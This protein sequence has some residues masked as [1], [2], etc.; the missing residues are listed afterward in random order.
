VADS[1]AAD[2]LHACFEP[3]LPAILDALLRDH[4]ADEEEDSTSPPT[5]AA[6]TTLRPSAVV[7]RRRGRHS[8]AVSTPSY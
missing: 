4:A 5:T 8:P 6:S 3:A 7:C 2:D 1:A